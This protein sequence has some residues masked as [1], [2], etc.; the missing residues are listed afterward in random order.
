MTTGPIVQV[1]VGQRLLDGDVGHLGPRPAEERAATGGQQQFAYLVGRA[2]AQALG[3][4]AVL[5]VDRHDLARLDPPGDQRAADH[6][7]LLVGQGERVAGVQRGQRRPQPDRAGDAVENH[8]TRHRGELAGRVRAGDDLGD[9][10]LALRVPLPLRLGVEGELQVL[11]DRGL[12]HRDHLDAELQRLLRRAAPTLS[13]PAEIASTRNRS[14]FRP[15]SS[16]AWV[17]TE[18]VEPRMTTVR[19]F[20]PA[21]VPGRPPQSDSM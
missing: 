11:G 4:R 7:G 2:A 3:D 15:I 8:V 13:P 12:G 10:E 1:R 20:T 5:G 21:I 17:P 6:Q 14:R 18:P 16:S 9:P 19:G